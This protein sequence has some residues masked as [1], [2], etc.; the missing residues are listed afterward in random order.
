[1]TTVHAYGLY[2]NASGLPMSLAEILQDLNSARIIGVDTECVSLE[3]KSLIGLAL[4]PRPDYAVWFTADSPYLWIALQILRDPNVAKVFHNSKFDYDVLEHLGIDERNF[5]DSEILAYTLNF[6][7]K[8]YNLAVHLGF[9]VP[10]KYLNFSF[11]KDQTML[12]IFHKDPD[13]VANKCCLDAYLSLRCW[14]NLSSNKIKSYEIDRDIVHILRRMEKRGVA[15]NQFS[16]MEFYYE[17]KEKVDYMRELITT[18]GC[19]PNSNQQVGI[20]LA[21][22]GHRLPYTKSRTQLKVDE[23]TL[24]GIDDPLAQSVLIYREKAKLLNTY[25]KPLLGLDRAYTH[26]NNTRVV[27]GRLSS[28]N[29]FNMQNIPEYFRE[30]FIADDMFYSLDASQ[31][32]LRT[33]AYLAQDRVMLEAFRNGEDIHE[34]TNKRLGLNNRKIAKTLNF[35]VAYLG[36]EQTVAENAYKAGVYLTPQQ[37]TDFRR[38]YFQT[39]SGIR[40]YIHSQREWIIKYGYVTTLY[41]RVRRADPTRMTDPHSRE[42]VIREMFN[43]PVQG[44]AAEIIKMMMARAKKFDLRIQVHDEM[45]YDGTCPPPSMFSAIAPFDIPLSLKVGENWG[46]LTKVSY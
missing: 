8:L 6:P 1:V 10:D 27:T 36:E 39:Y 18:K 25:I 14:L 3:D 40:D 44:T 20:V 42:T 37:A 41:G 12:E 38:R 24:Q 19:D 4:A 17:T 35:A 5:E 28:S 21:Q 31:I 33:I 30:V 26:Y 45:V 13:F 7:Q 34:V 22:K 15:V 2:N 46:E 9:A 23:K 43:M 32:E 16:L 11:E 29:P